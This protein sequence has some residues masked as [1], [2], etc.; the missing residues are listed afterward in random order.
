[1]HRK[2]AKDG[3]VAISLN[4]DAA[5]DE[6]GKPNEETRKQALKFL[7]E[8]GAAFT[9]L[10]LDEPQDFWQPRLHLEDGLPGVFVFNRAGKWVQF[11]V[12][13]GSLVK[14]EGKNENPNRKGAHY[15]RY[16]TVEALVQKLLQEK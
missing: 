2:Y 11:K 12:G 4:L 5:T 13:D 8:E 10:M 9:N 14:D 6:D 3:L 7:R 1:M 16:T 15:Y